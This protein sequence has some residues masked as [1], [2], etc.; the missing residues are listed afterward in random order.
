VI[1]EDRILSLIA[2]TTPLEEARL[3]TLAHT[4]GHRAEKASLLSSARIDVGAFATEIC[5]G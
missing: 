4:Y 1:P 3:P 2:V 5:K